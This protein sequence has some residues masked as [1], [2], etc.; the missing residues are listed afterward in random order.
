M[1]WY[2]FKNNS[3]NRERERRGGHDHGYAV[4]QVKENPE[5]PSPK[6]IIY[7]SELDFI[8]RCILDF[9]NI[10]TG[11]ELFGFWTQMGTPVVL[12]AVGPGPNA[13]HRLTSFVQDSE[14]VDNVEVELCNHTGLQH[15]GQWHSHHQLSL[16]HPSGG[17]VA[18]MMKGVGMPGFPRMLLC[19][20]NC[21]T[22]ATTVNAFNFHERYPGDYVHAVWDIVPIDSPYRSVID[23]LFDNRLYAPRTR[24]A[25]YGEMSIMSKSSFTPA[26]KYQQHW[27][28]EKVQNVETMKGFV[29]SAGL[30]FNNSDPS[31][32]IL[33]SGEPIISLY[34][35][36]F[37]ILFP[38]GFPKKA[39]R[40]VNIDGVQCIADERINVDTELLW[41]KSQYPIDIK[42]YEWLRVTLKDAVSEYH[43]QCD[44]VDEHNPQSANLLSDL[45]TES[46]IDNEIQ[47]HESAFSDGLLNIHSEENGNVCFEGRIRPLNS[48]YDFI[49]RI[50]RDEDYNLISAEYK[51]VIPEIPIEEIPFQSVYDMAHGINTLMAQKVTSS[52]SE[53]EIFIIV[54][55]L[56]H[57]CEC[58]E[59]NGT[60]FEE[61]IH[62]L[63]INNDIYDKLLRKEKECLNNKY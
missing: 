63:I 60:D 32:E 30:L 12:Y 8:S 44:E 58:S 16:A 51:R 42:F 2:N 54:T 45:A 18:S 35:G 37:R 20:G 11:G 49:I 15:I 27:L 29:R 36:A 57:Q 1:A 55:M 52:T 21:T 23:T 50:I 41:N 43:T 5:M 24:K 9:P 13:K 31:T 53:L 28:T 38:Y 17:D 33:D 48:I 6:A 26:K 62:Q 61:V 3:S 56:I 40:Y 39:P 22:S 47:M 10:E 7:K 25:A 4:H 14:Y 46:R 19:I 34:S 59:Q